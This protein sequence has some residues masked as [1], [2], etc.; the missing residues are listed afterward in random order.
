MEEFQLPLIV[1]T[2]IESFSL[3][4]YKALLKF[5]KATKPVCVWSANEHILHLFINKEMNYPAFG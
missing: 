1:F 3:C 4:L 5:S 2:I